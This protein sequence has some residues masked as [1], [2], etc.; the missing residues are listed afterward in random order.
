MACIP[1]L[2]LAKPVLV[3]VL[4]GCS[5]A[6]ITRWKL[7]VIQFAPV[8][9]PHGCPSVTCAEY[10]A[11]PSA[12]PRQYDVSG[13]RDCKSGISP[14]AAGSS[15][16][17]HKHVINRTSAAHQVILAVT[18]LRVWDAVLRMMIYETQQAGQTAVTEC[19]REGQGR[20]RGAWRNARLAQAVRKRSGYKSTGLWDEIPR[21][22]KCQVP[23][24]W[25]PSAI[26]V[27]H[28]YSTNRA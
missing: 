2:R 16:T 27:P 7:N 8:C 3:V 9:L 12:P 26:Q 24:R 13:G 5:S 22:M 14:R 23:A 25:S 11:R 6:R 28:P 15:L 21:D 17:G 10:P 18:V 4:R 19:L 20:A 1:R